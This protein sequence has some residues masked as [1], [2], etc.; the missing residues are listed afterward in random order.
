MHEEEHHQ[1]GL[2]DGNAK[3]EDEIQGP[4]IEKGHAHGEKR[5]RKQ[6]HNLVRSLAL[7]RAV[8]PVPNK[9]RANQK[10][11]WSMLSSKS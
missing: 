1:Q 9:A 7:R 5:Q 3:G 4:K 11:M 2:T 8:I 10:A 6:G